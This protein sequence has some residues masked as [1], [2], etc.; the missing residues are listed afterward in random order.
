MALEYMTTVNIDNYQQRN[1][2]DLWE[3][4]IVLSEIASS[5]WVIIPAGVSSVSCAVIFSGTATAKVQISFDLMAT[6]EAESGITAF[7]WTSGAVSTN[8]EDS[9]DTPIKAVRLNVTAYTDGTIT[10]LINGRK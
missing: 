3:K 2:K 8:T 7:D 1:T 10:L 6:L 9:V 4:S 5:N